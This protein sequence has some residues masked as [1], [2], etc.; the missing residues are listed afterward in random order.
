MELQLRNELQQVRIAL[1]QHEHILAQLQSGT[2]SNALS[3]LQQLRSA[4]NISTVLLAIETDAAAA[5]ELP[6]TEESHATSSDPTPNAHV[7]SSAFAQP[8]YA[9]LSYM[10][11]GSS[12][13]EELF[14]S[15]CPS[16]HSSRP[17]E[18]ISGASPDSAAECTQPAA[19]ASLATHEDQSRDVPP[20]LEL[21][22]AFPPA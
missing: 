2:D 6:G 4:P 12:S 14:S 15:P 19:P 3:V 20:C 22:V 10:D 8:E 5:L 13:F 18:S 7:H 1:T 16:P 9:L 11:N 17:P 21:I